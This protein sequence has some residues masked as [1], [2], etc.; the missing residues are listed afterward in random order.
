MLLLCNF[1]TSFSNH[2]RTL[3]PSANPSPPVDAGAARHASTPLGRRARGPLPPWLSALSAVGF[4]QS[5]NDEEKGIERCI[6][7]SSL[8]GSPLLSTMTH[9]HPSPYGSSEGSSE[10]VSRFPF[11]SF[12]FLFIPVPQMLQTRARAQDMHS[13][14]VYSRAHGSSSSKYRDSG[15]RSCLRA[16]QDTTTPA[17]IKDPAVRPDRRRHRAAPVRF[18]LLGVMLRASDLHVPRHPTQVLGGGQS[19]QLH[20]GRHSWAK[21]A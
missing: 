4:L 21:L 17:V 12:P 19:R 14:W 13:G 16:S 6:T 5:R 1:A 7:A 18:P 2:T 15:K 9:R 10:A 20:L 8:P 11:H 3:P